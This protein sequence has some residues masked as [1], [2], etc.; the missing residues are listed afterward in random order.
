M[1]DPPFVFVHSAKLADHRCRSPRAKVVLRQC[2]RPPWDDFLESL[3]SFAAEHYKKIEEFTHSKD[4]CV[5]CHQYRTVIEEPSRL[6]YRGI[7]PVFNGLP[8]VVSVF[9]L[10]SLRDPRPFRLGTCR[11]W[12]ASPAPFWTHRSECNPPLML[13]FLSL[14]A[15]CSYHCLKRTWL[16]QKQKLPEKRMPQGEFALFQVVSLN[17]GPPPSA[18]GYD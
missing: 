10:S 9:L 17:S 5:G 8:S 2:T 14:C 15:L 4:P 7:R 1:I 6:F 3:S 16:E 11:S 12:A 13:E 18:V